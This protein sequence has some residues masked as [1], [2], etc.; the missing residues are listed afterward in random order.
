MTVSVQRKFPVGRS[1]R[2]CS[3][4][5]H[6]STI[7]LQPACELKEANNGESRLPGERQQVVLT[8]T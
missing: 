4:G 6:H 3:S 7:P 2:T 1:I 5:G 8:P